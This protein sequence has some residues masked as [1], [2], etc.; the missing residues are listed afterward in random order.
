M[1][2]ATLP[3]LSQQSQVLPH[4]TCGTTVTLTREVQVRNL[5]VQKWY[6]V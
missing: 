2:N 5:K 6:C 4:A 1:T 3:L